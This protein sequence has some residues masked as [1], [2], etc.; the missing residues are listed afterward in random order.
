MDACVL[1]I[2]WM[3]LVCGMGTTSG[4]AFWDDVR[5]PVNC[6]PSDKALDVY[7]NKCVRFQSTVQL[8][9][10]TWVSVCDS[11]IGSS[12]SSPFFSFIPYSEIISQRLEQYK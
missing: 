3:V 6:K 5:V 4:V 7:I 12:P 10:R 8:L 9:A 11:R 2:S 1:S